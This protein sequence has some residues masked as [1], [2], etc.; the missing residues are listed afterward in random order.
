MGPAGDP[1][2]KHSHDDGRLSLEAASRALAPSLRDKDADLRR[3]AAEDSSEFHASQ[4]LSQQLAQLAAKVLGRLGSAAAG[5]VKALS[6][7]LEV[8][9][10]GNTDVKAHP[11]RHLPACRI[12][13]LMHGSAPTLNLSHTGM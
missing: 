2:Q 12:Q 4:N 7:L 5:E 11:T 3:R 1:A 10:K 6:R 8:G 9:V 13:T